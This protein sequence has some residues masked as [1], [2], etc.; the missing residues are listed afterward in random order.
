MNFHL[1]SSSCH[2]SLAI[3]LLPFLSC[4]SSLAISRFS[5]LSSFICLLSHLSSSLVLFYLLLSLSSSLVLFLSPAVSRSSS[6]HLYSFPLSMLCMSLLY[7]MYVASLCYV[8][9]CIT[10]TAFPLL[11][12]SGLLF[13][14]SSLGPSLQSLP[15]SSPSFVPPLLCQ[16]SRFSPISSLVYAQYG[17]QSYIFCFIYIL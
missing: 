3:P 6:F 16:L 4:H 9:R 7:V 13:Q 2:S 8:C 1:S 17:T 15:C 5:P 14:V 11:P 12:L 10:A